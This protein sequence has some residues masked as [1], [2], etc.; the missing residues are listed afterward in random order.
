[1]RWPSAG[2][3]GEISSLRAL[4]CSDTIGEHAV[5]GEVAEWLNAAVSKIVLQ[6]FPV[7]WV[8]IPPS[9]PESNLYPDC[10]I[11]AIGIIYF[12]VSSESK[13]AGKYSLK[14]MIPSLYHT[15]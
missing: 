10:L 4:F 13:T 8:R 2:R 15:R 11:V 9:P 5:A 7:T 14:K 3:W 6:V 1:M 12:C